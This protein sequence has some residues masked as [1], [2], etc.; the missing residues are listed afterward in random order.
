MT[1]YVKIR[2]IKFNCSNANA[3]IHGDYY[4]LSIYISAVQRSYALGHNSLMPM[5]VRAPPH[6]YYYYYYYYYL[7]TYLLMELSAS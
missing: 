5:E 3:A 4:F 6:H 1:K 2:R 7:L